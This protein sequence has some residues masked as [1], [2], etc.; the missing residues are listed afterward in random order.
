MEDGKLAVTDG[1][2]WFDF[3]DSLIQKNL[4]VSADSEGWMMERDLINDLTTNGQLRVE[5]ACVNDQMYLGMARPDLFIRK[6]DRGFRDWIHKGIGQHRAD[7]DAD[8]R[9]GR[10]GELYCER[11]G[12]AVL[13]VH[14]LY[15]R[16]VLSWI[17]E[18]NPS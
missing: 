16:A 3:F 13:H 2:R 5:V 15:R 10:D 11:A 4:L 18:R 8:Y 14:L 6:P 7:D 9:A 1:Q 17:H 12:G